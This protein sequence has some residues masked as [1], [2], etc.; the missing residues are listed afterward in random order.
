MKR[1]KEEYIFTNYRYNEEMR[2]GNLEE[3]RVFV[4]IAESGSLTAAARAL[5]MTPNAVSRRLAALELRTGS[6]LLH[7]TTRTNSLSEAGRVVLR[8]AAR[9][10]AEVDAAE[11]ELTGETTQ[12][13]GTVRLSLPSIAASRE[14]L[15]PLRDL[16]WEHSQLRVQ[17]SVSDR[18][19]NPV[20]EGL[21]LAI[22]GGALADSGLIARKLIELR[23]RLAASARYAEERGLPKRLADLRQHETLRFMGDRP[24]DHWVLVGPGGRE[25]VVDVSGRF[26]SDDSRTLGECLYAGLGI[27]PVCDAELERG[28]EEGDLVRVLPRYCFAPLPVYAVYA[29][30]R[31]RSAKVAAVVECVRRGLE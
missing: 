24:Q 1:H 12:F 31:R 7:R 4:Q 14:A 22:Q 28:V 29:S 6:D 18:P 16:M 2:L 23:P 30:T 20:A 25:H 11:R 15:R 13:A 5:D 26:E 9:I 8:R 21:D 27:G 10:L 19:V 17:V 3:L